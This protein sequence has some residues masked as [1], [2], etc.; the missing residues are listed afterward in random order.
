MNGEIKML[1]EIEENRINKIY[2]LADAGGD[3]SHLI[4]E[5]NPYELVDL[6]LADEEIVKELYGEI[7]SNE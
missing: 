6:G 2:E 1:I 5:D 7:E 4:D 3:F